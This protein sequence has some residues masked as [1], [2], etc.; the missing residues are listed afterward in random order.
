MP[1]HV[2]GSDP[3]TT[4]RL[5]NNKRGREKTSVDRSLDWVMHI[6]KSGT[7]NHCEFMQWM[8]NDYSH[9][10]QNSAL[11]KTFFA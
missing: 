2:P 9:F 3:G 7:E 8:S 11:I 5:W 6:K 10:C 4:A 1:C